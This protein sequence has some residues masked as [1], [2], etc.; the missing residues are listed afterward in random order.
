MCKICKK[1]TSCEKINS[2]KHYWYYCLSCKNIFSEK[3]DKFF[4]DNFFLRKLVNIISKI[5]NINRLNKLL[6]RSNISGPEFYDY[7]SAINNKIYN[8]WNDYDYKFL[9]YLKKNNIDLKNKSII[10]ISDEPGFIGEKIKKYTNNI[11]F[12]ALN[13]NT[14]KLMNEKI[15]IKTV[16]YDLNEDYIYNITDQKYD[17][18]I[19]RSCLNF[20]KIN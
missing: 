4:F 19:Y 3:K 6:L 20:V 2:Y 10:S 18:I 13:E 9:D 12:T 16:K 8:K 1:T 17:V 7:E 15:G 5:T 14:A 11:L